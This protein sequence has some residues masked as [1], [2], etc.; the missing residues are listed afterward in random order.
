MIRFSSND[1]YLPEKE[2]ENSSLDFLLTDSVYDLRA[3]GVVTASVVVG[4]VL[5]VGD[6]LHGVENF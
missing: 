6:Q 1:K 2:P 3:D 5:L 4:G